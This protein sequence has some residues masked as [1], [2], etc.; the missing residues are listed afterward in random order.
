LWIFNINLVSCQTAKVTLAN[1]IY[2]D[3]YVD[4]TK[5]ELSAILLAHPSQPP[6]KFAFLG[7]GPLPM[8]SLC[9][10][11]QLEKEKNH[12]PVFILNIDLDA[13][14]IAMA[15][16]VSRQLGYS[17]TSM[18][19]LCDRAGGDQNDLEDFD[20]VYLAALVGSTSEEKREI[21]HAV[22]S[23]MRL[24]AVLVIRTAHALRSLLYPVSFAE[25][26]PY[27]GN[28]ANDRQVVRA[29]AD[30]YSPSFELL[31]VVHPYNHIVNSVIIGRVGPPTVRYG[32]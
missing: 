23:R 9:I 5:M 16:K 30:L 13:N 17:E 2:Y 18:D 24:G 21:F 25:K 10:L 19:F 22:L 1:F 26:I 3:N 12:K 32:K 14:A 6:S 11:E 28:Q 20:V 27:A 31:M 15:S 7:C 4:L 29:S 8:T